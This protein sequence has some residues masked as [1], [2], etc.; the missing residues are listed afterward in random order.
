[1]STILMIVQREIR[2]SEKVLPMA[3]YATGSRSCGTYHD[4]VLR[5]CQG[6]QLRFT[7][8]GLQVDVQP[9]GS[10]GLDL[11]LVLAASLQRVSRAAVGYV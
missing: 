1:M 10:G 3:W 6:A 9:S 7:V 4:G 8:R 5:A 2:D 11:L